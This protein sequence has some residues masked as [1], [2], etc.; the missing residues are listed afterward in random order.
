MSCKNPLLLGTCSISFPKLQEHL[1]VAKTTV[2]ALTHSQQ[3]VCAERTEKKRT[4]R[5]S[6]EMMKGVVVVVVLRVVMF[7][8]IHILP[9]KKFRAAP[10]TASFLEVSH[11]M[12]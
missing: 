7:C 4:G 12:F 8:R 6:N 1:S 2:M 9:T 5:L 3:V 10:G 11:L